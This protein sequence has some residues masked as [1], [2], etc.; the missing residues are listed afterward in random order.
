[1]YR[2]TPIGNPTAQILA[3]YRGRVPARSPVHLAEHDIQRAEDRRHVR[4][5]V[6]AAHEVH[7]L[8]VGE[9]GRADLDP[10]RLVRS[11]GDEIDAEL[12]LGAFGR[13]VDLAGG[14]VEALGV[15]L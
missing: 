14:N 11:V 9:A 3:Y 5:H 12:P 15:E 2:G 8:E 6:A 13:D 7:R 10:V 4:Q 1:M